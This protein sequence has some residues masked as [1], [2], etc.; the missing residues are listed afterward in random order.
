MSDQR[1]APP[2]ATLAEPAARPRGGGQID[3]GEA[4]REAWAATWPN[5]G[6]LLGATLVSG[7]AALLAVCTIV[8]IFVILPVLWWGWWRFLLNVLAG[9]GEVRDVFAGFSSYG[10]NLSG[11][12]GLGGLMLV[13]M[14]AGQSV[15]HLGQ[16]LDSGVLM[17][18]GTLA[19]VCWSFLVM[20][21]LMFVWWF[22]VDQRLTP[23]EAIRASWDATENQRFTCLLVGLVSWLVSLVGFLFLVVGV[24]PAVFVSS[25]LQAAAYRQLAGR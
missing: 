15:Q 8:G 11:M 17:V 2:L 24:I 20:P 6:L 21:R 14:L 4:F 25:L 23:A 18:L 9:E 1:Y 7:I 5:L 19:S 16:L 13:I 12:L 3:I 22:L 10:E